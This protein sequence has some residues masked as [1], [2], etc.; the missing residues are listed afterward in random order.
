[1]VVPGRGLVRGL[2]PAKGLDPKKGVAKE[3]EDPAPRGGLG[4]GG[5][6]EEENGEK[7]KGEGG[8]VPGDAEKRV[9]VEEVKVVVL[10]GSVVNG[11]LANGLGGMPPGVEVGGVPPGV[12]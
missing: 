8:G 1:M 12:R 7:E 11:E 3:V 4:L 2:G 5:V 10:A 6:V 9:E